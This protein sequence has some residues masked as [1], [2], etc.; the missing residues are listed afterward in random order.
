MLQ[1]NMRCVR[2]VKCPYCVHLK[3]LHYLDLGV[4]LLTGLVTQILRR[5]VLIAVCSRRHPYRFVNT[6]LHGTAPCSS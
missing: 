6:H 4:I 1:R 3:R 5:P 2:Y